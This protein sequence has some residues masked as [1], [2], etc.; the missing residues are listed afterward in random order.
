MDDVVEAEIVEDDPRPAVVAPPPPTTA[1]S[2]RPTREAL[3]PLDADAVIDGM[4]AYQQLLPASSTPPT[5][6]PRTA[7]GS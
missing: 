6:R 2:V 1:I 5:T 4:Q 3:V 7:N